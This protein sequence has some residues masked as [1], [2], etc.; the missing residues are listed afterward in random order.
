VC[1]DSIHY[2]ATDDLYLNYLARFVKPGGTVGIAGAEL[3]R[4]IDVSHPD[5]L[6]DCW[7]HDLWCLHLAAWWRRHWEQTGIMDIDLSDTMPNGWQVLLDWQ[8]AVA[9]DYEL[10]IKALKGDR[11]SCP[12]Y[13]RVVDR[14]SLSKRP[15][16]IANLIPSR[17]TLPSST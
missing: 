16:Q 12:G 17:G 3:I 5:H 13:V 4:E 14:R 8:K 1:V 9:P 6:R 7:T 11:G 10:E 15:C 2:F